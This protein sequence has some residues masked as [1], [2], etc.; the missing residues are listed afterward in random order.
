[1]ETS[2]IY[3]IVNEVTSQALGRTDIAA[4]DTASFVAMGDAV[5]NSGTNVEP[6]L[7]TLVQRIGRTI[8]SYRA[9]KSQFDELAFTD[10][11]FGA[12]MQKMKTAMPEAIMDVSVDL[13]DGES[14]DHYIVAK[15]Q[16]T[17]KLFVI[18]S[19]YSFMVTLQRRWLKEA[20]LS[21]SAMEAFIGSI[22]GELQNAMA[23]AQEELGRATM[24]NFI[25]N[26]SSAQKIHLLTDYK[27]NVPGANQNLTAAQA[28]YDGGFLRY[29]MAQFKYYAY[30][31]TE[32]SVLY[33]KEG[34]TRHTPI[35]KQ[36]FAI[37]TDYLVNMETQVDYAAFND[38][39]V[40]KAHQIRVNY[41]QSAQSPYDIEILQEAA[42]PE[43]EPTVVEVENILGMIFDEDALGTYRKETDTLTTPVN[44][45]GAYYNTFYHV[46]DMRFNDMS[47]NG[48]VFLVD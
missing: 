5:L 2:Q 18:R 27:A 35:D 8:V 19:P 23:V 9:Y 4:I 42:D 40:K 46:N 6:W 48:L 33:N 10:M 44:A 11:T 38:E 26:V 17:Q 34:I 29:A 22:F 20:F 32:M 3:E 31:L 24:A 14:I 21:E 13:Q 41:W 1:M 7:N 12:I 25:A 47:E 37:M 45:R 39:Y 36:K 16:V 30:R 15:P 43:E 28:R